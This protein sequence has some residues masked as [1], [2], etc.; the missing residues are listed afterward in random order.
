VTFQAQQSFNVVNTY[1]TW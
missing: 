1:T